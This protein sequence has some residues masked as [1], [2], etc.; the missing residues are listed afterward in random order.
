MQLL[1][2]QVYSATQSP[3]NGSS[4]RRLIK[5]IALESPPVGVID[6][7]IND[8]RGTLLKAPLSRDKKPHTGNIKKILKLFWST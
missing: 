8:V 1:F 4:P 6:G 7:D 5:Q 3:R 2:K